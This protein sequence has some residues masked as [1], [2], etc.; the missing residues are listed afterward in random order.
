MI[1]GEIRRLIPRSLIGKGTD[2]LKALE[3]WCSPATAAWMEETAL[4]EL[5]RCLIS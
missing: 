5:F 4:L 3:M 2:D 1:K